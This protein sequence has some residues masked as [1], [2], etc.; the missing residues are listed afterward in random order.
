MRKLAF[1]LCLTSY[2]AMAADVYTF[3]LLPSDGSVQGAPGSTVGWGY[4][5]Q[6]QSSSL[7]LVP[8]DLNSGSFLNGT[9]SSLFDAPVIAPGGTAKEAFDASSSSGLFQFTWDNSAPLGFANSGVFDLSAQWWNGDP[10]AGGTLLSNAPGAHAPYLATVSPSSVPEPSALSLV[11][12]ALL[13]GV[14]WCC[15]QAARK[16]VDG[17]VTTPAA[18]GVNISHV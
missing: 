7:W 15:L 18:P 3:G 16:F 8:T 1:M 5:L 2:A 11:A 10:L 13:F 9:P 4:T 14:F 6:N 12:M 17:R